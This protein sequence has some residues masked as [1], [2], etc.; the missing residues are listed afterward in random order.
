MSADFSYIT[1]PLIAHLS[2]DRVKS[3]WQ[4][5]ELLTDAQCIEIDENTRCEF[6]EW[7]TAEVTLE[8]ST[9]KLQE[10]I[11]QLRNDIF[12][13]VTEVCVEENHTAE[14]GMLYNDGMLYPLAI[15]G[16]M[17]WGDA[18]TEI[19]NQ[20]VLIDYTDCVV[21]LLITW[22]R[23]DLL[24]KRFSWQTP[25]WTGSLLDQITAA[26]FILS[27]DYSDADGTPVLFIDTPGLK[28]DTHGP[29]LRVYLNDEPIYQNP[30]YS[31]ND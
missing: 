7:T 23:E 4:A 27:Q 1:A 2:A 24:A 13:A 11:R 22:A 3:L 8:K 10:G 19:F 6:Y 17:S 16:G 18:P 14:A 30:E 9:A 26:G 29:I 25:Q 28:E 15:T 20:F 21:E 31:N 5:I 12:A